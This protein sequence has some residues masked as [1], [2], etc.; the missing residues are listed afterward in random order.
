MRQAWQGHCG[1]GIVETVAVGCRRLEGLS[2]DISREGGGGI[3]RFTCGRVSRAFPFKLIEKRKTYDSCHVC[4][5]FWQWCYNTIL[6]CVV[7]GYLLFL[8]G[9]SS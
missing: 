4:F 1:K 7:D 6:S 9:L 3:F 2:H 8:E 5:D